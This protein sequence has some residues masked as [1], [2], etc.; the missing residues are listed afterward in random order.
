MRACNRKADLGCLWNAQVERC[1]FGRS[2]LTHLRRLAQT[3][4]LLTEYRITNAPILV[5]SKFM[6]RHLTRNGIPPERIRILPPVV[7][8]R[9]VAHFIPPLE[10]RSMIFAGR[11]T[12]EKGLPLL[13]EA[14]AQIQDEWK[15]YVAGDGPER[16]SYQQL[17]D[18][19]GILNRIDFRGWV[20]N[21]EMQELY[22]RCGFAIVPSIW[23]EP[24]GRVGPEAFSNGRPVIAFAVGGIPD[25]LDDRETGY[26]VAPANVTQL[27]DR[28]AD[29]LD[30][31]NEQERMGRVALDLS[32]H[33][34][35]ATH[36]VKELLE[37]FTE[38]QKAN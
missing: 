15:L 32:H 14:L 25:W 28:I 18:R 37:C 35:H 16:R 10:P 8:N 1:C 36:H 21:S 12:P 19:L 29:L 11:L 17:A 23:P 7:I 5:G 24:Y 3:H 6:Q 20:M 4:S 13:F 27:K 9:R 22:H 34:W 2:P 31:S 26:L 30:N 38:A 33:L